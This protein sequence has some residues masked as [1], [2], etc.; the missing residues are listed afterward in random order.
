[1][2]IEKTEGGKKDPIAATISYFPLIGG[3]ALGYG[4]INQSIYF[5]IFNIN[6]LEFTDLTE[7]LLDT[8][9]H[10][11]VIIIPTLLIASITVHVIDRIL[12]KRLR[13]LSTAELID[14]SNNNPV[15]KA[16]KS[17]FYWITL[18]I[19][20]LYVITFTVEYFVLKKFDTL[21]ILQASV[22][23]FFMLIIG[24]FMDYFPGTYK[25][26]LNKEV[27]SRLYILIITSI[28]LLGVSM[29]KGIHSGIETKRHL[30]KGF[31]IITEKDTIKSTDKYYYVGKTKGYIF[32][33]NELTDFTD[34]YTDKD[35]KLMH[36]K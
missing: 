8:L 11:I 9:N 32:Y 1:M 17:T 31:Y 20:I 21:N 26:L 33:Y 22:V 28:V 14:Y 30:T 19:F 5:S 6:I 15:K 7:L 35:V 25:S 36:L 4:I 2:E 12:D 27:D 13:R 16:T 10:L 18:G 24:L 34:V 29:Y 3:I 23:I